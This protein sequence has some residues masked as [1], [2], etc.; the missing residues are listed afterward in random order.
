MINK[1]TEEDD[2]K[3]IIAG[4]NVIVKY[5]EGDKVKTIKGKNLYNIEIDR[6]S[7]GQ[8]IK[9]GNT[10]TII[11]TRFIVSITVLN[12]RKD[13]KEETVDNTVEVQ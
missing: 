13:A 12:P 2:N 1:K 11:N 8:V 5:L 4:R 3:A 7:E 9:K 6:T 10:E